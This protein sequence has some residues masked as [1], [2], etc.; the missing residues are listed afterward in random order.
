MRRRDTLLF[1][2]A[3]G[4]PF[5]AQA[6]EDDA[7]SAR[8]HAV[9]DGIPFTPAEYSRLLTTLTAEDK[10][11]ED[12]YSRGGVVEKLEQRLAKILGKEF[13]VWL[14]TGT[15]ANRLAVRLLC[16]GTK[17]R[18]V[19]QADNHLYRDCGDCMQTLSA[20]NVV[21]LGAGRPAFSIEELETASN[22]AQL[23]R[24][25]TPIGAIQIETPVRRHNGQQFP[26]EQMRRVA[27]WARDRNIGL[28]LDGA[29]LFIESAYTGRAVTEYTALFDTV[30]VSMWKY[31]NA[32]SGAI[33]AG[34]AA[35]LADLYQ[36]RRMFG[37]G[38]PH[39]WPLA[40]VAL[41]TL[42]GF[43]TRFRKAVETSELVLKQL[44]AN[45]NFE[46]RRFPG[47]TNVFQ[48]KTVNVNSPVYQLRLETAGIS[49]AR[50]VNEWLTMQVNET[51]NRLPPSAIYE[52]FVT[53]LG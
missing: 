29:R 39:S 43:E 7:N 47:G 14:P 42:E 31:F 21:P 40:A 37:G 38:L 49:A 13:A 3:A 19:V 16:G 20:I 15:L 23:G 45:P 1:P 28:H 27:S 8:I 35:L 53:A 24:V 44:A 46:I 25:S 26:F 18:A 52:R 36:T 17:H 51:W 12:T 10:L 9:G 30:Y 34:P 50:P 2:L 48:L 33:L 5:E 32:A 4:L 6:A 11:E 22:E 41:H